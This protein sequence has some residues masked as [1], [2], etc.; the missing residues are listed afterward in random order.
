MSIK[1]HKFFRALTYQPFLVKIARAFHINRF[2]RDIYCRLFIPKDRVITLSVLNIKAKFHISTSVE[3]RIIEASVERGMGELHILEK[4]ITELE[5]D[6]VFYDIGASL[7]THTI[8]AAKKVGQNGKVISFEPES[9]SYEKLNANIA[10]NKLE[11]VLPQNI[12]LG[13][14]FEEKSLYSYG[15][16]FG[17]F[18]IRGKGALRT[19]NRIKIIP[20]D[21]FILQ[22]KLPI[23]T[24]M[25][26]DVEG[27]EYEVLK[28]LEKTLSGDACRLLCVEVH[29][30]MLPKDIKTEN[31][32]DLV[33]SYD[34]TIIEKY[35][36]GITFHIFCYKGKV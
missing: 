11:N 35:E 27:F 24:V 6:D 5:Q 14:S 22:K 1:L 3:L 7:G 17:S 12:A 29:P 4:I 30:S 31:V 15:G 21:F 33:K 16:G 10:L 28:G 23:P 13:N 8:F 19:K 18:N 36:R 26:I 34:F 20:G 32:I 25:K 2:L 9:R